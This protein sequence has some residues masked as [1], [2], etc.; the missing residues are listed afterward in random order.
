MCKKKSYSK[1]K[2]IILIIL[3][4]IIIVLGIIFVL[5]SKKQIAIATCIDSSINAFVINNEPIIL[6]DESDNIKK[7]ETGD[8]IVSIVSF[9]SVETY[10][11][12][13]SMYYSLRINNNKLSNLTQETINEIVALGWVKIDLPE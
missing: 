11:E 9:G 7:Y 8:L 4:F 5:N 13:K 6:I 12:Q 2:F 1:E 10:P 3:L